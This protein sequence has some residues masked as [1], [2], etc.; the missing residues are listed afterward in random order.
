M[1]I[2]RSGRQINQM[3]GYNTNTATA[4]GQESTNRMHQATSPMKNRMSYD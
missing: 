1:P 4:N 3:T 2:K